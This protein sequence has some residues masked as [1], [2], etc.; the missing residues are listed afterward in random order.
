M[1]D[2]QGQQKCKR[3]WRSREFSVQ[4]IATGLPLYSYQCMFDSESLINYGGLLLLFVAV[5]SQ[6]GLF[7]CFFVPSG[8]LM[9]TA[10]VLI[11]E[12]RFHYAV[13]TV[14]GLL[15][16]AAVLG[17]ITGYFFGKKTGLYLYQRKEHGLFR[18]QYLKTAEDFY[19]RHGAPA[20]MIG[21]FLPLIRTFA[22]IVSGV[23][24]LRLRRFLLFTTLGSACYVLSFVLAGYMIA[25]VPFLKPYLKYMVGGIIIVVT[26]PIGVRVVRAFKARKMP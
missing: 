19:D 21:P 4:E 6:I 25:S 3:I 9:F 7:F 20:L 13:P 15:I 8:G 5:Y 10:G 1:S 17:N 11:A 18:R 16:V 23:I 22:P 2:A 26:I 12:G 24:K 14:C